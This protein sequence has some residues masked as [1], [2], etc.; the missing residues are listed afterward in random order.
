MGS[1]RVDLGEPVIVRQAPS[2]DDK[3]GLA[4]IAFEV[5]VQANR[6]TPLNV[7][8][9]M[10]LVL[11]GTAPRGATAPELVQLVAVLARWAR[12]RGIRM[13]DELAA[14]DRAALLANVD[15]LAANGLLVRYDEGSEVVYAIEPSRHP[16]ASYYRNTIVHH[17][18]DKALLELALFKAED[19]PG[20]HR[21]AAFWA[22][23]DRLRE[24]FKFEFY[25]PPRD[26]FR[27]GLAAE[28]ARIDARWR[29]RLSGE[30]Q[31]VR[32]LTQRLQ[33]FIGHAALLTFVEAYSV[34]V[35]LL[36]R[37]GPGETLDQ[38]RC[39]ELALKEGRQAYLLR[40]ISSE[41]SIGKILFENGYRLAAN[42][43]LAGASTTETLAGRRELLRELR[44]L[45][46][47][48]ERL[49]VEALARAEEIMGM[50]A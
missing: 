39:V 26:E 22:E 6:V 13:S 24:L 41:A 21:E 32:R 15:R 11:L 49:R 16:V 43:G 31:D 29:E 1:V 27:A 46:R 44:S 34:V 4:K 47:R 14:D 12:D 33:P 30:S 45:S 9:V 25:Y 2:P 20:E 40:R 7:T 5:A 23:T 8:A 3:L 42:R 35:D 50:K 48:M 37:L 19:S 28:L 36:A 18:L 10:C 38:K 17:F